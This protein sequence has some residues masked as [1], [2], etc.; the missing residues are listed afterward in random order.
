[1][2]RTA[3]SPNKGDILAPDPS[4]FQQAEIITAD[5]E[6]KPKYTLGILTHYDGA[7]AYHRFRMHV[8]E[9]CVS[10]MRD[11]AHGLDCELLIFDNGSSDDFKDNL[12]AFNADILVLAP[13]MG[14]QTAQ[15]KM[16]ELARGEVFAFADDDIYFYPGWLAAHM[17]I[18]DTFPDRPMLVSGSPQRTAFTW[19]MKSNVA[20][21][22]RNSGVLTKGNLIPEECERQY[23]RSI[24]RPEVSHL[25]RIQGLNDYLITWRGVKA[26]AHAHHMQFVGKKKYLDGKLPLSHYL[27]DNGRE[28][29]MYMDALG[30][31]RLTTFERTVLHIGNELQGDVTYFPRKAEK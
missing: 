19:G 25:L 11:G 8:V 6:R 26:W 21:C 5:P 31:L 29:D 16:V 2:P 18:L 24:G 15:R 22:L 14:K 9:L 27:L 23:A 7:Q 17:E 4:V 28:W 1:M 12:R 20:F 30:F 10:S 13:N 3:K